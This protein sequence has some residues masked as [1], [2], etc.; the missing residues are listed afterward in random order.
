MR[1][2]SS[3][4]Q[5]LL[6]FGLVVC[7]LSCGHE[8]RLV[9][10]TVQPAKATFVTPDP[11]AQIQFTALGNYIHPPSTLDITNQ[12][13]WKTD[14]PQ[15]VTITSA[16]VVSP[17]GAGCGVADISASSTR[18]TGSSG[19]L[20]IGSATVTVNDPTNP[21][22]PGSTTQAVLTVT[23]NGSGTVT[24][25]PPG[26]NCPGRCITTYNTGTAVILTGTPGTGAS[27]VTWNSCDSS[28]GSSC[29]VTMSGNKAVTATF[30]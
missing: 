13:T 2:S 26:I 5:V 23:L 3:F 27:S 20:I 16:G 29:A 30:Q 6:V 10:I 25:S 28:S 4:A 7:F 18:G 15:L 24:S 14:V 11:T 22:C 1:S 19:N 9:S 8:R 17:T 12:V 21:I